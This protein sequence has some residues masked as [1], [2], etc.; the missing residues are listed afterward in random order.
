MIKEQLL[1][2]NLFVKKKMYIQGLVRWLSESES[3]LYKHEQLSL[4]CQ[5]PHPSRAGMCLPVTTR[6]IPRAC[7]SAMPSLGMPASSASQWLAP[8]LPLSLCVF[9]VSGIA[10]ETPAAVRK[11]SPPSS[12]HHTKPPL[13]AAGSSYYQ[14]CLQVCTVLWPQERVY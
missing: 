11:R 14:G 10:V 3:L 7:Q 12:S 9:I 1:N 2:S 5:T 4:N 13:A 6:Q 8:V